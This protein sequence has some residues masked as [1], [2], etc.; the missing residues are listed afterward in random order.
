MT[1]NETRAYIA[2]ADLKKLILAKFIRTM[3]YGFSN[4]R[5]KTKNRTEL[6]EE[7]KNIFTGSLNVCESEIKDEVKRMEI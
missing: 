3:E 6:S 1:E 5:I 7:I 2:Y 4:A